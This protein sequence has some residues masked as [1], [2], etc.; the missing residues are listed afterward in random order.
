MKI[1][2][3]LHTMLA[4]DVIKTLV[5]SD[6]DIQIRVLIKD[7]KKSYPKESQFIVYVQNYTE[8]LIECEFVWK[9]NRFTLAVDSET[10]IFSPTFRVN[11]ATVQDFTE[12]SATVCQPGNGPSYIPIKP[13][14][15]S[16]FR[17]SISAEKFH[18][19]SVKPGLMQP[20]GPHELWQ[21][22][23]TL[24]DNSQFKHVINDADVV[25]VPTMSIDE[26]AYEDIDLLI[27]ER[28]HK[29]LRALN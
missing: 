12:L 14:T 22:E 6:M 16:V 3:V 9:T 27:Q 5:F 8:C 24:S 1:D 2:V 26:P 11:Q 4:S 21:L 15:K 13:V 10:S 7:D 23:A 17:T 18:Q 19:V 20:F 29:L 25:D 28:L